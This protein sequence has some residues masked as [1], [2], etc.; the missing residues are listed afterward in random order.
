M[1]ARSRFIL[2]S[3][4]LLI[5]S[6][7]APAAN[8]APGDTA[9][10]RFGWGDPLAGSDE[11]NYGSESAP[12]V[13]DQSKW[14][15]AGGGVDQCWPGHAGNGRRCDANTRVFGGFLRQTGEADGDS[16]WLASKSGRQYGRW[17]ARIRSTNTG[18]ANGREYHPLLIIWP[19]SEQWPEDGEYDYLENGA[20]GADCAESFIHYP[21]DANVAV[22]QEFSRESDCGAPLTE[23]HNV[24]FEWTAEHVAGFIDGEEWFRF[25]GGANDVREC[26][27]CMASGHQTIQLDNFYGGDMTPATYELDWY[28]EYAV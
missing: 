10:E 8:A 18:S 25:S 15:L 3:A 19:D 9:A 4:S 14:S 7:L 17:E 20:P 27:Q 23:W 5:V 26:I 16:G 2:A 28:R 12:A 1:K 11:F 21:H 13:P 22:Q 6:L 24:A